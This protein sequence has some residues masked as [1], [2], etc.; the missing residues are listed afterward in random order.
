MG[1]YDFRAKLEPKWIFGLPYGTELVVP[2]GT[3]PYFSVE[4]GSLRPI[5]HGT[6][7]IYRKEEEKLSLKFDYDGC[8]IEFNDNFVYIILESEG[9]KVAYE[10]VYSL[11]DNI[12]HAISLMVGQKLKFE[13]ISGYLIE[14]G[15]ATKSVRIPQRI[16]WGFKGYN[17]KQ[18]AEQVAQAID[19]LPSIDKKL[20]KS[21]EYYNHALFL[22]KIRVEY[23]L[24]E[25]EQVNY[26]LADIVLN[27]N[28]SV[29]VL[30]GEPKD[31]DYHDNLKK[32]G[33]DMAPFRRAISKLRRIRN[34]WDV[35]H[36]HITKK[37]LDR[38]KS[39]M[40]E[41]FDT[42]KNVILQYSKYYD[43]T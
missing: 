4:A 9:P 1:K 30:I 20:R 5:S 43:G 33:I 40:K 36:H 34:E 22:D 41:S 2:A 38:L 11:L 19:I 42:T 12:T 13:I 21:L 15:K 29:S 16:T 7:P 14:N 24:K 17:L 8:Q 18:L 26:L 10:R 35:A 23:A 3:K 39:V 32:Y 28:K 31:R 6:L 37:Q 27:L 25:P